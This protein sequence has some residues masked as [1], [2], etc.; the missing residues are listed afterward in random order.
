MLTKSK[1]LVGL[2][3]GSH[4]I[5]AVKVGAEDSTLVITDSV[6]AEIP[7]ELERNNVLARIID[8]RRF[9]GEPVVT[10]ISGRNVIIR[11][12]V[13]R[14][15]SQDEL[16]SAIQYELDKHIPFSAAEVVT[17]CQ[18]LEDVEGSAGEMKVLLVAV[19][20]NVVSDHVRLLQEMG[21]RP[22]AIDVDPFAIGNA[23]ELNYGVESLEP[24]SVVA[25]VDVG[26]TKTDINIIY[27]GLSRFSRELYV[28]GSD[29]SESISRRLS[30]DPYEVDALKA[31]PGEKRDEILEAIAPTLDALANEV[32]LSF[33]FFETEYDRP[34]TQVYL[35]GGSSLLDGIAESLS[36]L[37]GKPVENWDPL[38]KVNVKATGPGS[39][40]LRRNASKFAVAIGLGARIWG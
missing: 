2:D 9:R 28:A 38:R 14:Q 12:I 5:K 21:L 32:S 23:F 16:D 7:S 40:L 11:Y 3:I 30:V 35:S 39:E 19:K 8:E 25:L 15:M 36:S 34:V 13:M 20:R 26:A 17:S 22:A 31:A 24:D 29:I 4:S 10:A 1:S 18:K 33:D 37:F 27:N 6:L